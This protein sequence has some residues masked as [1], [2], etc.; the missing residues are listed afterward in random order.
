MRLHAVDVRLVDVNFDFQRIH[1]HE[2]ADARTGKS[3]ASRKWRND[4]TDLRR[5]GDHHAGEWRMD[6]AVVE[7]HLRGAD[8]GRRQVN[9]PAL[10]FQL[11]ALSFH[12]RPRL[13]H[14]LLRDELALDQVFGA[15]HVALVLRELRLKLHQQCARRL[16]LRFSLCESR[17]LLGIIEASQHLALLSRDRPLRSTPRSAC[18]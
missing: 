4:L 17:S 18:R 10:T 11:G 16:Q 2:R 8:I 5:L 6:S 12:E 14:G 3:S 1:V 7:L 9:L 15:L 13:L